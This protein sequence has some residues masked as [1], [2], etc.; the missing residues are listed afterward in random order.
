MV[1][2]CV[3]GLCV[4]GLCPTAQ[5]GTIGCDLVV[6]G[7]MAWGVAGARSPWWLGLLALVQS[8]AFG[9]APVCV[10]RA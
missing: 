9:A 3:C 5:Q 8:V 4:C 2:L 10:G 1:C 6:E 7:R